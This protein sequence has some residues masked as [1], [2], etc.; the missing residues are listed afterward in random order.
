[1]GGT[2]S[3]HVTVE[4]ASQPPPSRNTAP[5]HDTIS[6]TSWSPP[7]VYGNQ[8]QR[9][10]NRLEAVWHH[11]VTLVIAPAGFGKTTAVA[12]WA[13]A[14]QHPVNWVESHQHQ[15]CSEIRDELIAISRPGQPVAIVIDD[16]HL[17][18][19]AALAAFCQETSNNQQTQVR[20]VLIGRHQPRFS[21][22]KQRLAGDVLEISGGDLRFRAAEAEELF[23]NDHAV[24]L[25]AADVARLNRD[26]GG[27]PA[28]LRLYQLAA[29]SRTPK[30]Q[31]RLLGMG[32]LRSRIGQE[33]LATNVIGGLDQELKAFLF[34]TCMLGTMTPEL[35]DQ[36]RQRDDST[37]LLNELSR[38]QLFVSRSGD[39][40]LFH[41]HDVLRGHLE[42]VLVEH[43]APERLNARFHQAGELLA[44]HG[45]RSDA[46]RCFARAGSWDRLYD[47]CQQ[48]ADG[49][50]SNAYQWLSVV[51][52][53]LVENDPWLLITR[54]RAGLADGRFSQAESPRSDPA[55]FPIRDAI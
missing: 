16:F 4:G 3:D 18:E 21:L 36:L 44:A 7:K 23:T 9:L 41:Y 43:E 1:M 27:W 28:G 53:S 12:M 11:P 31:R 24:P 29:Q 30:E 51:P 5:R 49:R 17:L 50:L 34:D 25:E 20:L 14:T 33:Y 46:Q 2:M 52:E 45:Q 42:S 6:A 35:C 37:S 22:S 13:A 15:M 48:P 55:E 8:R 38:R 40:Q 54:A 32:A 39:G 19:E 10:A 26:L 47:L